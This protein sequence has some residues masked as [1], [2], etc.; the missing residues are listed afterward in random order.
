MVKT[1]HFFWLLFLIS[2]AHAQNGN[3]TYVVKD[4]TPDWKIVQ[5]GK[6]IPAIGQPGREIHFTVTLLETEGQS[7]LIQSNKPVYLFLNSK[8]ITQTTHVALSCDSL[9]QAG[10]NTLFVSL[11]HPKK[12]LT[13]STALVSKEREGNGHNLLR[14]SSAFS[15]FLIFSTLCLLIFFTALL[16]TN[17]QLTWDYLNVTK[18]FYFMGQDESPNLLRITSSVN[19]LIYFFCSLLA[20][21][22][23]ITTA[24]HSSLLEQLK[25]L[26]TDAFLPYLKVWLSLSLLILSL[27]FLKLFIDIMV[28][29]IFSCRD[30]A[31]LQFFNSVRILL[32]SLLS[33]AV[34]GLLGFALGIKVNYAGLLYFGCLLL[35]AGAII[36]FLK[37]LRR[38]P[39]S[40]FHLF[41]YLCTTEIF[42]LMIL[43][44]V[45]LF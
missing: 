37:L 1:L 7:L 8:L 18:L 20:S 31:G 30:M 28:A 34:M 43:I 15:D 32:V 23:L 2:A 33:F 21:Q 10:M 39:F 3:K 9:R 26:G 24:H 16:K 36:I 40:T 38:A 19:L 25:Y 41:F 27:L 6:L 5:D 17:P 14:P 11:F 12:I 35:L 45:L 22:A 42:P 29:R 4:L 13:L 44:K